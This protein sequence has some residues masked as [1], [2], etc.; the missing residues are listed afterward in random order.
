LKAGLNWRG[1]AFAVTIGVCACLFTGFAENPPSEILLPE[2]KHYGYPLAWRITQTYA[3]DKFSVFELFVD[4][5]FWITV[6]L[7]I[8]MVAGK[9]T[10]MQVNE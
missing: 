6:F 8:T 4:C 1:L 5:L 10:K 2:Y 3:S 9:L 7:T